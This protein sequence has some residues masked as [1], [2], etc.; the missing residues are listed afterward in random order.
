MT[1]M[2]I[3]QVSARSGTPASTIRYYEQFGIMPEPRREAGQRRYEPEVLSHLALIRFARASGFTL[4]EIKRLVHQFPEESS[5]GER[6]REVTPQRIDQIDEEIKRLS[7]QRRDLEQIMHCTCATL[8]D[9]SE[10]LDC[11]SQD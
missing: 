1:G 7:R 5:A 8:L 3:G 2:T 11:T 9:C 10:R 4:R 6:W